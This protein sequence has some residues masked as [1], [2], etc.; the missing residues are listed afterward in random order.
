MRSS[1]IELSAIAL[2]FAQPLNRLAHWVTQRA[3][4]DDSVSQP[5]EVDI[6][7]LKL[8]VRPRLGKVRKLSTAA[9][10]CDRLGPLPQQ[11]ALQLASNNLVG[12]TALAGA[13]PASARRPRC[14]SS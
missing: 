4:N 10:N 13:K 2:P 3:G 12:R 11:A 6:S 9:S 1:L 14:A 8:L 5:G 7:R